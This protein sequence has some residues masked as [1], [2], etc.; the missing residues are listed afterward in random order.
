[1]IKRF[2]RLYRKHVWSCEKYA[3]SIGVKIGKGC[4]IKTK[5]F[6]SEPT[7]IEIGDYVRIAGNTSF[8]T[9]GGIWSLRK[10]FNDSS[11]DYFGKIKVGS[12]TYIGENCLIMPGVTIGQKCIIGAGTVLTKS[13]PDGCMVGG[14]PCKIIGKTEDFYVRIKRNDFGTREMTH[15][16]KLQFISNA[17]ESL[18]ITKPFLKMQ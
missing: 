14:N 18:F 7:L 11:L 10:I 13:V 6:S 4:Y 17:D 2:I 12:Y 8:Y 15:Q 16:Q 3:R 1:M 5:N 9:H